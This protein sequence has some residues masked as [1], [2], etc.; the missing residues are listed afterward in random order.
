MSV[1]IY[2]MQHAKGQTEREKREGLNQKFI[3]IQSFGYVCKLSS[4]SKYYEAK[5]HD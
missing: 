5:S 4:K 1:G 2:S 3:K